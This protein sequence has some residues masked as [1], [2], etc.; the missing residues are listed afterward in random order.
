MI[1]CERKF[2]KQDANEDIFTTE[3]EGNGADV[4]LEV[5]AIIERVYKVLGE[6]SEQLSDK[7][8]RNIREQITG[9]ICGDFLLSDASEEIKAKGV[10]IAPI[11]LKGDE[12]EREN[13]NP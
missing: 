13:K 4:V 6:Q 9:M 8:L 2:E 11:I 12:N 5:H 1:K 7:F 10:I 3:I